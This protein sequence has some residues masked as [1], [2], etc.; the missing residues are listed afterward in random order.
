[1]SYTNRKRHGDLFVGSLVGVNTNS[2]RHNKFG[3]VSSILIGGD[4]TIRSA[5]VYWNN[6]DQFPCHDPSVLD[7]LCK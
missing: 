6:G 2:R 1:M 3:I 4:G 7:V 5:I